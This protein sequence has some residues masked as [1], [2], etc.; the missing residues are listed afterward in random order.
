MGHAVATICRDLLHFAILEV[1][2]P[3]VVGALA[4]LSVG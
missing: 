1:L 2:S 4:R 3:C